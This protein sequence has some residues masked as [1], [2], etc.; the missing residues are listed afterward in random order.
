[1]QDDFD[2]LFPDLEER[3][4]WV[5]GLMENMEITS[6][7]E[8]IDVNITTEQKAKLVEEFI[9]EWRIKAFEHLMFYLENGK[10]K[11]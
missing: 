9:L 10:L 8:G 3:E 5:H 2:T 6:I 7:N 4:L 1:M 11:L